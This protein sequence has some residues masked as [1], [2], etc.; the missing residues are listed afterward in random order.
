MM[1]SSDVTA[2]ERNI[3]GKVRPVVLQCDVLPACQL[4]V[5]CVISD[6][7][8]GR[9]VALNIRWPVVEHLWINRLPSLN[10]EQLECHHRTRFAL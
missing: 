6:E 8:V 1:S 7:G 3:R 9:I 10:L 4:P 2:S 5:H